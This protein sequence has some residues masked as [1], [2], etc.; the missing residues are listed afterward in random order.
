MQGMNHS[1]V[2]GMSLTNVLGFIP[3]WEQR[4]E[5]VKEDIVQHPFNYTVKES[6]LR[7]WV[8]DHYR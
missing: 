1:N 8:K 6:D 2:Q 7:N 5:E 3:S 4:R